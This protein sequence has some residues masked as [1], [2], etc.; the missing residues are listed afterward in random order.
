MCFI[1]TIIYLKMIPADLL[2]AADLARAQ[3]SYIY[4]IMKIV[5]IDKHLYFIL[6][7]F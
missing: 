4:L 1:L 6:A 7:N 3:T 2:G 5:V